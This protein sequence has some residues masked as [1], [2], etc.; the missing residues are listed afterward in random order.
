MDSTSEDPTAMAAANSE[1]ERRRAR[2]YF[3]LP[4]AV[5]FVLTLLF[6]GPQYLIEDD[7]YR[8]EIFQ[9]LFVTQDVPGA[10]LAL[11][12][13]VLALW[14]APRLSRELIE[15]VVGAVARRPHVVILA[16][17]L[18]L[19]VGTEAVYH[20]HPLSLDEWAPY[21][22]AEVFAEGELYGRVPPELIPRL[23]PTF[24]IN[25]FWLVSPSSGEV[26]SAY[27]PGHAL[28]M[29]PFTKLGVPW[30]LN[31]L[32]AAGFLFLLWHL[33][34]RI[35]DDPLAPG[36]VVL[37]TLASPDIL[38]NG[39]SFYSMTSHLFLSL[40]YVVL[41]RE[42]TPLRLFAAGWVGALALAVHNP[43][44]HIFVALPWIVALALSRDRW[45]N[46][47]WLGLGYLPLTVVL[48]AGWMALRAGLQ[49]EWKEAVMLQIPALAPLARDA[50]AGQDDG[51]GVWLALSL[52]WEWARG[53]FQVPDALWLTN[54]LMGYLKLALWSVP[55]LLALAWLGFRGSRS[56][57]FLRLVGFSV[58]STL[59]GYFFIPISQ[60]HGWGF[61]YF[62]QVWWALPLLAAA[63]LAHFHRRSSPWFQLAATA[64]LLSLVLNNGLRFYQ[65]EGFIDRHLAQRPQIA[66]EVT[67]LCFLDTKS[68]Y[69]RQ[70]L[71]QNDP[72]LRD[73]MIFMVS[74]G[75][76]SD[77]ALAEHLVPGARKVFDDGV[78]RVWALEDDPDDQAP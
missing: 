66:T 47:A 32:L 46:L 78:N 4:I 65:I 6:A 1:E 8:F 36:W 63:A 77:R 76:E 61:R 72:F 74:L 3:A 20:R 26:A 29:A 23:I 49:A 43:I 5:V 69:Y 16:T 7:S 70:D 56:D 39:L 52:A 27:W 68:G 38:A 42:T 31:P 30:L 58:I 25:R 50:A 44:P 10:F 60:G 21:Y 35:F 14:L 64:I 73:K 9:Y 37:L 54:R 18:G 48:G 12:M 19:I 67:G 59:L 53:L 55:G 45:R 13:A 40:L 51:G 75:E 2:R 41:L 22:Q 11:A 24:F 15:K 34:R 28:L 57:R 62:H 71:V 33:A 17:L